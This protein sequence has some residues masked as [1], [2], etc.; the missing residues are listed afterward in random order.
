MNKIKILFA[1]LFLTLSM[2]SFAEVRYISDDVFIYLHSGPGLDY[3]IT[4]TLKVGTEV[5]TL[6]YDEKTKFMQV[7]ASTG[8]TGWMKVS[9]L[10]KTLPA[11]N[12]LPTVQAQLKVA[13]DKLTTIAEENTASLVEKEQIFQEQTTLVDNLNQEKSLLQKEILDLKARNLELDLLQETK[14]SR[15][16]MQWLLNGGG[17]LFFGLIIGLLIPFLPRRKKRTDNW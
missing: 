3:R 10:Q 4:G 8:R 9:E 12:L 17:V 11:K 7:K 16:Q 14:E 5:N 15:I 1:T 6:K 13:N 2:N